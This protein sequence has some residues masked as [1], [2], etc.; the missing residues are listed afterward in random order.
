MAKGVSSLALLVIA[1]FPKFNE[2]KVQFIIKF[3]WLFIF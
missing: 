1:L 3:D 2:L